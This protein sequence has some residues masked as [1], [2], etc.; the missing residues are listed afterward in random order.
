MLFF[1]SLQSVAI[2]LQASSIVSGTPS[3]ADIQFQV[4]LLLSL[5]RARAAGGKVYATLLGSSVAPSSRKRSI[6][7]VCYNDLRRWKNKNVNTLQ[8]ITL[9]IQFDVVGDNALLADMAS[10]IKA[11]VET[12]L[13]ADAGISIFM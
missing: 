1:D 3:D 8:V 6:N 4:N 11:Y 7:N 5:M 2:N 10:S 13:A 9:T 12:D